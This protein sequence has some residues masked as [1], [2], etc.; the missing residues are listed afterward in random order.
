MKNLHR[1]L[2][3][4]LTFILQNLNAQVVS[5][6]SIEYKGNL[7]YHNG[8]LYSGKVVSYNRDEQVISKYD[9][10]EGVRY[11]IYEGYYETK[12][13]TKTGYQ[14]TALISRYKKELELKQKEVVKLESDSTQ[15]S[16]KIND[17]INYN[18]GGQKKLAKMRTKNE[19]GKL[20]KKDKALFDEFVSKEL[21]LNKISS[22]KKTLTSDIK[23]IQ[24]QITLEFKKKEFIPF[25]EF[26]YEVKDG[27]KNGKYTKY[28]EEGKIMEEGNYINDKQEG[29]WKY[30]HLNGNLKAIGKF[31]GGDGSNLGNTGIPRNGREGTWK[32]YYESGKIEE[33]RP[34]NNGLIN[35][36][37]IEYY[38]NG[39]KKGEGTYVQDELDGKW[40]GYYE[41]GLKQWET[42][43]SH[44]KRNGQAKN[45]YS[46]GSIESEGNY[47]NDLAVGS[48]KF[49]SENGKLKLCREFKNGKMNGVC[50]EFYPSGKIKSEAMVINGTAHGPVKKYFE[51]GKLEFSGYI[52]STSNT[53]DKVYG[54]V[55]SY[56][57]DGS[58]E[59]HFHVDKNG[60]I[61]VRVDN[62]TPN[63]LPGMNDNHQC[64][65][66]G[67]TFK[68]LGWQANAKIGNTPCSASQNYIDKTSLGSWASW[69]CS[70]K[71]AIDDCNN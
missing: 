52:D 9:V 33:T 34:Y 41:T 62:S 45:Y 19:Q 49:Y 65:W 10:K 12:G 8:N 25:K 70:Q 39:N 58:L 59:T 40:I 7:I 18:L 36:L 56:N 43:Y 64:S 35:G 48:H 4:G 67:H 24:D 71:C 32:F 5:V 38:E 29:E 30:F 63:K 50:K 51:S 46:N 61:T 42:I 28:S 69:H 2:L 6:F 3:I 23:R 1:I 14:D 22:S 55:K 54:E 53:K 31:L 37:S 27:L 68:G 15:L 26:I 44:G 66:C 17:F 57:E 11:G 16:L 20:N 21:E 60:K 47:L 13:F